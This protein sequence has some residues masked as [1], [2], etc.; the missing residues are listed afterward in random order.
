MSLRPLSYAIKATATPLV[1][2]VEERQALSTV[3]PVYSGFATMMNWSQT[4]RTGMSVKFRLTEVD[5]AIKHPFAGLRWSSKTGEGHRLRIGITQEI[6]GRWETTMFA[7]EASL[8]WWAEDCA[9]GMQV[10]F[11][12]DDGPDGASDRHPLA[13]LPTGKESASYALFCWAIGDN[14]LPENPAVHKRGAKVPFASMDATRQAGIKCGDILFR[15]WCQ[16]EGASL[17]D[18]EMAACLPDFAANPEEFT[19]GVVCGL[20][21][22]SSRSELKKAGPDGDRARMKWTKI[23]RR[24]GSWRTSRP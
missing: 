8:A 22:I 19:K 16:K 23:L 1:T 2:T 14:E 9:N 21:R 18:P 20:C 13:G 15:E 3:P 12:L 6:D 17:M 5:D 24:F 11:R 4:G 10:T 7:G